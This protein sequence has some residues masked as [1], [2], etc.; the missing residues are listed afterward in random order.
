MDLY[1]QMGHGMKGHAIELINKWQGGTVI[2]SSKNMT[3]KQMKS[4]ADELNKLNGSIL[5]DPQFCMPKISQERLQQHSYWPDNYSTNIFFNGSGIRDMI[6]ILL[7]EYI[8]PL[9]ASGFIIPSLFLDDINDDWNKTTEN[10]INEVERKQ[11]SIP[12]FLTL[13]LDTKLLEKEESIHLLI[14]ELE[15]Y[16]IDGF[17][18]IPEHPSK[19]YLVDNESWL[20]NLLDLAAGLK[21][22]N[23]KVILGYSNHQ[24]LFMAL[25]KVDAI[26]S[27]I[28]LKTRVFPIG[29][30]REEEEEIAR[31]SVWYYCPQALSEY[32]IPS[33]D[34]AQKVG[35]LDQLKT[36][37]EFE[38]DY[39]KAL[40][41]GV[42]PTT[43]NWR[44]KEAFRHYLNYLKKQC[45]DVSKNS[46]EN[47]RDY[48]KLL[49]ETAQDLSEF[50]TQNGIRAKH[51]DF[52]NVAESNLAILSGFDNIRGLVFSA[53]WNSL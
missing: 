42:Q 43:V 23:K 32:Q 34:I 36:A 37:D 6:E 7:N 28:W 16:P 48:L 40:F 45:I 30:F 20:L 26:C 3:L 52:S 27:G 1:I 5:L 38:S 15:D 13:C 2:L 11:I 21:L 12:K 31:R 33:L 4:T 9:H 24:F 10:I 19:S 35:L 46:Y 8:Y 47:T 41:T 29:E 51:R 49:F 44:E 39:A 14:E 17:Y 25:A 18:I 53:N 22:L 50:F